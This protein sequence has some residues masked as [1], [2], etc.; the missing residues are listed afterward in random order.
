[1]LPQ[2]P[3]TFYMGS[4]AAAW[5]DNRCRATWV[6]ISDGFFDVGSMGDI[7]VSNSDPNVIFAGTGSDGLRSNV[8][9]GRGVYTSW[10][11]GAVAARRPDERG[12]SAA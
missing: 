2:E 7:D 11:R 12:I 10:T 8:S 3:L 5:E 6:N 4:T 9:I 1:M